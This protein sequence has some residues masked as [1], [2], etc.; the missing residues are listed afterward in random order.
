MLKSSGKIFAKIEFESGKPHNNSNISNNIALPQYASA[1]LKGDREI[2]MVAVK[3][4]WNALQYASAELRDDHEIVIAAVKQDKSAMRFASS[5]LKEECN[6]V[7]SP[8]PL[9]A[10]EIG[11]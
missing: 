10:G 11:W 2:V 7:V 4:Y 5:G 6:A 1:E 9:F 8:N 3:Q